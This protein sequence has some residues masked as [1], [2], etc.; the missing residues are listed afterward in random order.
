MILQF[1]FIALCSACRPNLPDVVDVV[2]R[3]LILHDEQG[4]L[5]VKIII[6]IAATHD[7]YTISNYTVTP[8]AADQF[9]RECDVWCWD[10]LNMTN[11]YVSARCTNTYLYARLSSIRTNEPRPCRWL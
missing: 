1:L 9:C 3:L 5:P 8:S 2:E 10:V 7:C 6:D 11:G 4:A